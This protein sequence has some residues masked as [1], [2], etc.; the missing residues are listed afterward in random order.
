T[1][2]GIEVDALMRK[3][4]SEK[5]L[6]GLKYRRVE[7]DIADLSSIRRAVDARKEIDVVFHL[8][9]VIAAKHRQEFF[10]A[11]ATGTESVAHAVSDANKAGARVKRVVYVS[12]LAAGGCASGSGGR[13]E[14]DQDVP[15]SAY[16]A[17]KRAGE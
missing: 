4:A 2:R 17:S 9:G 15:V 13:Q 16:G 6:Q 11:N 10:A 1:S 5:N 8:A 14:A 7:G 3:T 12:S